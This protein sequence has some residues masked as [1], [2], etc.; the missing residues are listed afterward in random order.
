MSKSATTRSRSRRQSSFTPPSAVGLVP[1]LGDDLHLHER[2]DLLGQVTHRHGTSARSA[3]RTRDTSRST[4]RCWPCSMSRAVN[5][6]RR[7]TMGRSASAWRTKASSSAE[8]TSLSRPWSPLLAIGPSSWAMSRS[9]RCPKGSSS[10]AGSGWRVM[11]A[12][13]PWNVLVSILRTSPSAR[14][15]G[16]TAHARRPDRWYLGRDVRPE[17]PGSARAARPPRTP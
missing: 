13:S 14:G 12:P 15:N 2:G 9:C 7:S 6:G 11:L 8:A 1:L 3:S 5:G 17:M 10:Q 4:T 16:P